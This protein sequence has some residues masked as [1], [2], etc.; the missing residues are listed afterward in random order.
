LFGPIVMTA[1]R[2]GRLLARGMIYDRDA[3]PAMFRL[4]VACW[5]GFILLFG[6]LS[7]LTGIH[8]LQGR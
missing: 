7:V 4:G 1:L 5:I 8:L 2:T 6:L 3:N